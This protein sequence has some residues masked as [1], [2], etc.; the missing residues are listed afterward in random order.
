MKCHFLILEREGTQ[1][2]KVV[3]KGGLE[4]KAEERRVGS[5]SREM[6]RICQI[7]CEYKEAI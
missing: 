3:G 5:H 7:K 6:F 2:L 4:D 1:G